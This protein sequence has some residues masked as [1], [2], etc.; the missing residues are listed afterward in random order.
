MNEEESIQPEVPDYEAPS[1]PEPENIELP[2][3]PTVSASASLIAKMREQIGRSVLG[4]EEV[5]NQVLAGLLAGG[6]VLLE[7]KP[8]LGKTTLA[9]ALASG[10]GGQFARCQ[11]TPDLLP[12]DI[13]GFNIFNQ[14]SH[15]FEFREGPVFSDVLLADE[16]NRA[17]PRT[18][19]AL[20]EAMA[21]D[22]LLSARCFEPVKPKEL[23]KLTS[24]S[25]EELQRI[26]TPTLFL[27]GENEVLYSAQKAVQRL[28]AVMP[29]IQT[30]VIPN[31]GHDLLL[32]QTEMVNQK[33]AAFLTP[34]VMHNI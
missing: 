3:E 26:T 9:K 17:T 19:S 32:V 24:M 14:S 31:A 12:S 8:G 7:G 30:E 10:I 29:H 1:P 21:D 18:Q 11:C 2:P 33:I 28:H 15:E 13:S 4:Q 23:P 5:I 16:I 34:I 22:F 6:H 27:V 20:L 25:D